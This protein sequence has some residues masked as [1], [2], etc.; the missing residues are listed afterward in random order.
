MVLDH[1]GQ[2]SKPEFYLQCV[3]LDVGHQ[4]LVA[5]LCTVIANGLNH[6]HAINHG[7]GHIHCHDLLDRK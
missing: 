6:F 3:P 1:N 4:Q 7:Y 5:L 2:P